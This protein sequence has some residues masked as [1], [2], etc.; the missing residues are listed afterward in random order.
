MG[1]F[2]FVLRKVENSIC[3]IKAT[4]RVYY[5]I[6]DGE[7]DRPVL[8]YIKGDKYPLMVDAGK[9]KNHV[10]KF[11]NSNE[12]IDIPEVNTVLFLRPTESLMVFLQRLEKDPSLYAEFK[13]K[14]L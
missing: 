1:S 5:L 9:S 2:N 12:G 14:L 8:G 4:E 7:I 13:G 6:N 10:E 3:L 11:N